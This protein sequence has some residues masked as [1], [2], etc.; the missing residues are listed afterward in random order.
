MRILI[1]EDE[2]NLA[3]SLQRSLQKISAE[4]E[5]V[6]ILSTVSEIKE[7]FYTQKIAG[8]KGKLGN[9]DLILSDIQLGDG[10]VFSALDSLDIHTHIAFVTAFNEY[11]LRV[12]DYHAI[13]YIL[14]PPTEEDL[15]KIL[16]LTKE[17]SYY[18]LR[19]TLHGLI[20]PEAG[21][22]RQRI[23]NELP[24]AAFGKIDVKNIAFF[25]IES[26]RVKMHTFDNKEFIIS[27]PLDKL[28]SQLDPSMFYRASRDVIL[29]IDSIEKASYMWRKIKVTLK[30]EL[31]NTPEVLISKE[32]CSS[33]R[34][35]INGD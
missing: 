13:D 4:I 6:G 33:F 29:H 10:L 8:N 27:D 2:R 15:R 25:Y 9:I 35:W 24:K 3:L 18:S 31:T 1:I 22:Y 16:R 12:F 5:V 14:K 7:Y 26:K 28:M 19:D 20:R 30:E 21:Q 11:V 23:S 34:K 17:R 32:K